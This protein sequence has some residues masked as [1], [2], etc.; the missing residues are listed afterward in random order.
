MLPL[1]HQLA[2]VMKV[3]VKE[4][5]IGNRNVFTTPA[6]LVNV[7]W[8]SE[9]EDAVVRIGTGGPE[10]AIQRLKDKGAGFLNSGLYQELKEFRKFA[11]WADGFV[12]VA[13]LVKIAGGLS[14]EVK[15]LIDHLGLTGLKSVTFHAGFDGPAHHSVIQLDMPGPRKGLLRLAGGKKISLADL[16]PLPA[17]VSSFSLAH[18]GLAGLYDVLLQGLEDGVGI[19]Q[20]K[21]RETVK[22]GIALVEGVL[23]LKLGD[24]LFGSLDGLVATYSSPADGPFGFG[25]V[26]LV[27]LK[28]AKKIAK[29]LDSLTKV[30]SN[31]HI[32]EMSVKKTH[33]LDVAITEFPPGSRGNMQLPAYAIHQGWLVF[34]WYPQPLRGF[35]LRA[36]GQL[37][38][39]QAPAGLRQLLTGFPK[40]FVS[41]SVSDP[42]P[43]IKMLMALAPTAVGLINNITAGFGPEARFD[44][45]LLPNAHEAT[46]HLFPNITVT[47]DDGRR[48]RIET[49]SSLWLPF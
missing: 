36:N 17:D 1:L 13:G 2:V 11:T 42:R 19:Y 35:V 46:R 22:Q 5:K 28:N 14:P 12:D 4:T 39:W 10:K 24:D 23:G 29:V 40:E 31:L 25:T 45:G 38:P 18:L 47:T 16:P 15:R 9:R 3:Q 8:W 49:R 30:A 37:P 34:S 26:Y 7:S 43:A 21:Q 44:L 27:K 32:L 6:G 20:P 48:L 41:I 33:Y